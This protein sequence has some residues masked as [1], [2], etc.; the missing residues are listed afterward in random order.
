MA[1]ALEATV[2]YRTIKACGKGAVELKT[3]LLGIERNSKMAAKVDHPNFIDS[4]NRFALIY[5]R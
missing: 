3:D 5:F 2:D 1:P 4:R